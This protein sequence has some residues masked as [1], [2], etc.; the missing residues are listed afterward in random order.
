[1]R[2]VAKAHVAAAERGRRGENYLLGGA[3][4]SMLQ[5]VQ[6]IGELAGR[7]VPSR[8]VPAWLLH[9]AGAAGEWL[10]SLTGREPTLTLGAARLVTRS[11][12]CDCS[13]AQRELG[14]Q[15]VPLRAMAEDCFRWLQQEGQLRA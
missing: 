7:R 1:V 8:P 14:Y 9:A 10:S 3:D 4:A 2:E 11:M 6:I 15:P 12:F 5:L 13:K